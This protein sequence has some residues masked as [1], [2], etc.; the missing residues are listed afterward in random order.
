MEQLII[1]NATFAELE[2]FIQ[3]AKNE[4]WN[5][6]LYDSKPFYEQD[7]EGF[8]IAYLNN[9]IVG[10]IS[11]VSYQKQFGFMG[12]YIV[13]EEYRKQ[14]I[15]HQLFHR[16]LSHLNNHVIG[17]DGVLNQ[18]NS[19][20]K[21][22]FKFFYKNQRFQGIAKNRS[23]QQDLLLLD[24]VSVDEIIHY[25]TQIFGFERKSFLHEWLRMKE[26]HVVFKRNSQNKISGYGLIRKCF[27][28]YKIGPLFADNEKIAKEI[29]D[30]LI[31]KV[32]GSI[33]FIDIPT[34]NQKALEMMKL[35]NFKPVFETVRMYKNGSPKQLLENV[36]GITTFELG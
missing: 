34:Y 33:I 5:P 35:Y 21:E 9:K 22:G 31:S 26:S 3:E 7:P 15:G 10:S 32:E 23:I 13:L 14:G 24:D 27:Q 36:F 29:L 16:A 17:L 8:F 1:K 18:Q 20:Q 25:D 6:G 11:A 28:G 12:F 30:A 2:F 4:G 19:Y